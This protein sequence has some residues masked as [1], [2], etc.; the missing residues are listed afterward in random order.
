MPRDDF[1]VIT[2]P[3]A[4]SRPVPPASLPPMPEAAPAAAPEAPVVAASHTS[5]AK[6]RH[7]FPSPALGI[8]SGTLSPQAGRGV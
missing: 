7:Q 1:D 6:K 4:P 2:G 3:P 5:R 8:A